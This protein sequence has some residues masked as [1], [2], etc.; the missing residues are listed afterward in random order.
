[1]MAKPMSLCGACMKLELDMRVATVIGAVLAG[2]S[3]QPALAELTSGVWNREDGA[4]RVRVQPCGEALCAINVW[5]RDPGD[6]K[7]GDRLVLNVKPSSPGVL[8]GT[9][10]DPK[11]NL[12]FSSRITYSESTMTTQGCVLGGLL[13]KSVKWT[14]R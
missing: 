5:I 13:C 9:A 11:R 4:A 12:S 10:F 6:E 1:M 14:R 3:A 8:V 7:V 2:L